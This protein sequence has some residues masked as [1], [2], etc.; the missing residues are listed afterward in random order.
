MKSIGIRAYLVNEVISIASLV[1]IIAVFLL[2]EVINYIN[3]DHI[4]NEESMKKLFHRYKKK[5]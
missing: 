5:H 2:G 1:I 3:N 4:F